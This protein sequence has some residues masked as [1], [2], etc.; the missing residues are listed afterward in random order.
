VVANPSDTNIHRQPVR[1]PATDAVVSFLIDTSGSMKAQRY[2]SVAVLVDTLVRALEMAEVASEVLGF[3]T[4]SWSGGRSRADWVAAG[5]PDNPGRLA[6]VAHVVY[7]S[8]DWSWR[9]SRLSMAAM[10]RTDHYR[11]GLDGEALEWAAWRLALRPER[12]RVLVLVSDGLPME[13]S[14]TSAN[15]EGYLTDHLR[16][17][18]Q[19]LDQSAVGLGP[20]V[21]L[22]AITLEHDLSGFVTRSVH[23]NLTGTLTVG[24]YD[25]LNRL[26]G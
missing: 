24:T 3:T 18:W 10:L 19:R 21:E 12:R 7:K 1:R 4:A 25:V 2:Q 14:T 16:T 11:E 5:R 6:D 8:A 9:Q 15:H 22:G 26:L 23:L 20:E 13:T 17:V